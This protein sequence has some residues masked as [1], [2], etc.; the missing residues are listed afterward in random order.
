VSAIG[1]VRKLG[2]LVVSFLMLS[3]ITCAQEGPSKPSVQVDFRIEAIRYIGHF[4]ADLTALQQKAAKRF[5]KTLA[6][7]FGFLGFTTEPQRT[8]LTIT[9]ANV[10][11]SEICRLDDAVCPKE[12]ILRLVLEQPDRPPT[13]YDGWTYLDRQDFFVVLGGV[14]EEVENLDRVGF[15]KLNVSEVM[16]RIFSRVQLTDN[17]HL[18]WKPASGSGSPKT[19]L[20]GMTVPLQANI[21]CADQ[22]SVLVMRSEFPQEFTTSKKAELAVDAQGPFVPPDNPPD[23]TW[24]KETG[25]LFGIPSADPPRDRKWDSW[26]P[27]SA[28]SDR[29]QI[30]ITGVFMYQYRHMDTGCSAAILPSAFENN[31]G[32][33][34]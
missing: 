33:E 16:V 25:N 34:P 29:D 31:P 5:A 19:G 6:D 2:A 15:G 10:S 4:S 20:A 32:R 7:R 27:L 14:D 21:L 24:K 30:R 26:E 28:I 18:I 22:H 12:T 23:D 3:V 11:P 8:K 9:L 1:G 13:S 17:A